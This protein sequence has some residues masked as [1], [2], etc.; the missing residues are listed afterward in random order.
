[1]KKMMMFLMVSVFFLMGGMTEGVAQK[2]GK[3]SVEDAR[4]SFGTVRQGE[5]VK[6]VFRF[7]SEVFSKSS[8]FALVHQRPG[9]A[10]QFILVLYKSGE[11]I[12][13][14]S[15][16]SGPHRISMRIDFSSSAVVVTISSVVLMDEGTYYVYAGG[17]GVWTEGQDLSVTY[18]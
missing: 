8:Y 2:E 3:K 1:M 14:Y 17:V 15:S 12:Y 6:M 13:S 18:W 16:S 10:P 7:T 4:N 5:T 9:E 11:I